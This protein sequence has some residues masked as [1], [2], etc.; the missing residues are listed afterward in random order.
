FPAFVH[1]GVILPTGKMDGEA[2][3]QSTKNGRSPERE[4]KNIEPK[5]YTGIEAAE[6]VGEIGIDLS[7][8]AV[9]PVVFGPPV[10]YR[11]APTAEGGSREN[12][13]RDVGPH[14]RLFDM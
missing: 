6:R 8:D 13:A 5:R 3:G 7:G 14:Q 1:R 11:A 9:Q 4:A 12:C 2:T 10:R